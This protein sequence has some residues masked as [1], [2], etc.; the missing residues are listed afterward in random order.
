[1]E[2]IKQFRQFRV[3]ARSSNTIGY[4]TARRQ[5]KLSAI[6]NKQVKSRYNQH[7]SLEACPMMRAAEFEFTHLMHSP[8]SN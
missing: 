8:D 6:R 4:L 2:D 3:S 1:M 5:M 7:W